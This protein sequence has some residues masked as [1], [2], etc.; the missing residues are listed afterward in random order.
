MLHSE[1]NVITLQSLRH[2]AISDLLWLIVQYSSQCKIVN[3]NIFRLTYRYNS[4]R[5][6]K[7]VVICSPSCRLQPAVFLLWN[8]IQDILKNYFFWAVFIAD[9]LLVT[10]LNWNLNFITVVSENND[11][12]PRSCIWR[13][14]KNCF[15]LGFP[16]L[17]PLH[18]GLLLPREFMYS[19]WSRKIK[20]DRLLSSVIVQKLASLK[21]IQFGGCSFSQ[22]LCKVI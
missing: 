20:S 10:P 21:V 4:P 17:I 8:I 12:S 11:F 3:F 6:E 14:K 22:C 5:N 13:A 1:I 19:A 9:P 18:W 16:N 2:I 15:K 7:S